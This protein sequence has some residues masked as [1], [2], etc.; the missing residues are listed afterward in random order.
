MLFMS[1]G[2][3]LAFC[4]VVVVVVVLLICCHSDEHGANTSLFTPV[5]KINRPT[6]SLWFRVLV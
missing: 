2:F 5:F 3:S 1:L 4:I 6:K